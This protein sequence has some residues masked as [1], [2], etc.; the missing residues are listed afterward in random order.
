MS[1]KTKRRRRPLE[2]KNIK[3]NSHIKRRGWIPLD[4]GQF[5]NDHAIEIPT[6]LLYEEEENEDQEESE[7][8]DNLEEQE[9]LDHEEIPIGDESNS[10]KNSIS[11]LKLLKEVENNKILHEILNF[12]QKKESSIEGNKFINF[13]CTY[14]PLLVIF[15]VFWIIY[16]HYRH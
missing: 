2:R 15:F 10:Q 5:K 16:E 8:H 4:S 1:Y 14:L 13:V 6:F 3:P 12:L 11:S 7:H 9:E